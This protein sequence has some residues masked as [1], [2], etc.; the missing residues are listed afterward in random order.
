VNHKL[1][2]VVASLNTNH[3]SMLHY[4][5][6]VIFQGWHLLKQKSTANSMRKLSDYCIQEIQQQLLTNKT[7]KSMCTY[8]QWLWQ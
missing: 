3:D 1:S 4:A 6:T 8:R 5:Y 7:R 2:E